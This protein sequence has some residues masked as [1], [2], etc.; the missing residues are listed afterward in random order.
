MC[1][2]YFNFD[3]LLTGQKEYAQTINMFAAI[4]KKLLNNS[5][6]G[7]D[8]INKKDESNVL[9]N[10]LF[11]VLLFFSRNRDGGIC[12]KALIALG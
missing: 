6:N 12:E 11:D 7:G 3:E 2:R 4:Q 5:I 1:G 8:F 10:Q 9:R